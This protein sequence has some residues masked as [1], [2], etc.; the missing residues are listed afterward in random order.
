[1]FNWS[2]LSFVSDTGPSSGSGPLGTEVDIHYTSKKKILTPE[3]VRDVLKWPRKEFI[4]VL[5]D[6]IDVY[7]VSIDSKLR[8]F[9]K[10]HHRSTLEVVKAPAQTLMFVV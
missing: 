6:V 3:R 5:S 4:L 8:A 1:M 7:L 2:I 9:R 10:F